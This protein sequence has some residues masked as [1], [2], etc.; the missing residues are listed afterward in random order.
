M[1]QLPGIGILAC[2]L[3]LSACS[4]YV[5]QDEVRGFKEG[6]DSLNAAYTES[7]AAVN[8]A[9]RSSVRGQWIATRARL[10]FSEGCVVEGTTP[11]PCAVREVGQ[12]VPP[13]SAAQTGAKEAAPVLSALKDYAA[14]LEMI[15]DANDRAALDKATG[16]LK[17][18]VIGIAERADATNPGAA[19]VAAR[20]GAI[21]GL[22]NQIAASKLDKRRYQALRA[23]VVSADKDIAVLAPV[24]GD[25]LKL[26]R[27]E[28]VRLDRD[29]ALEMAK[30]FRPALSEEEYRS[31]L[32]AFDTK[33][34]EMHA[35][36][37]GNP[38]AA[39]DQM[40]KAHEKLRAAL[41]DPTTQIAEVS[42]AVGAFVTE[43]EAV[44]KA[45]APPTLAGSV[46]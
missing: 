39:V 28:R 3:T 10:F 12:P 24:A 9:T 26:L 6:V 29:E 33:V 44:Q 31:R 40:V 25:T 2:C 22:F 35:L 5:Y 13:D 1:R 11:V 45:F 20:A 15:V 36:I 46:K 32:L 17:A 21:T 7:A 14:A 42:Q 8:N 43:A 16:E 34:D 23:G 4:P 18:Q 38:R 19:P 41:E 30:G 27:A 37:G